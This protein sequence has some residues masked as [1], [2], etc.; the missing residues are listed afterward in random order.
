M[1]P[2]QMLS[3]SSSS[4]PSTVIC[5]IA[6][7]LATITTILRFYTRVFTKAGLESDDWFLFTAVVINIIG[8][9]LIIYGNVIDPDGPQVSDNTD[10]DYVYTPEDML[11]LRLVM[12]TC[13]LYFTTGGATRLGIL[14]MYHRIFAVSTIFGYQLFVTSALNI[15]WWIGCSLVSL[16]HFDSYNGNIFD[17]H[18][19]NLFWAVSGACEVLL[20]V[21]VL[22]L[23]VS[24]VMR[25]HLSFKQKLTVVGVFLL[26]G[27]VIITGIVKVVIGYNKSG[28][29][30]TYSNTVIWATIHAAM[31]IVCASLPI[32][33]PLV[34][35]MAKSIFITKIASLFPRKKE[36]EFALR[37][38][39]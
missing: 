4:D 36:S 22:A 26:G 12:A 34:R 3:H 11:F 29:S 14:L 15:T 24:I 2:A 1:A 31:A 38:P 33:P 20:D 27:F 18:N 8:L 6:I 5:G 39:H 7:A 16:V 28:G 19:G 21:L 9:G 32:F 23:P 17:Y 30:P 37:S 13:V 35:R 10:P 25:M